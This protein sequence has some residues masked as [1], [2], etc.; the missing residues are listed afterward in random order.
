MPDSDFY[1]SRSVSSSTSVLLVVLNVALLSCVLLLLA[2]VGVVLTA[3]FPP[4]CVLGGMAANAKA[5]S[6]SPIVNWPDQIIMHYI[7]DK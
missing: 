2:A 3:S 7:I 1:S 5:P 6:G 4:M